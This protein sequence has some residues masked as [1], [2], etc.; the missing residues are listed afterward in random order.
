MIMTG[1][2]DTDE[3]GMVWTPDMEDTVLSAKQ[4]CICFLTADRSSQRR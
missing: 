2:I 4:M 3:H 1:L